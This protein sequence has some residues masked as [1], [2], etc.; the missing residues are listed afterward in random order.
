M[1]IFWGACFLQPFE[2]EI[3]FK[4]RSDSSQIDIYSGLKFV[5]LLTTKEVG[6][7]PNV[8]EPVLNS[9]EEFAIVYSG[10]FLL[11]L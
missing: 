8:D 6:N 1:I 10:L 7:K 2:T 11:I 9:N 4:N 5:Q 3:E